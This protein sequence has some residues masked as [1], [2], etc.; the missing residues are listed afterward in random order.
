MCPSH[1]YV[2]RI[3][4]KKMENWTYHFFLQHVD[5]IDISYKRVDKLPKYRHILITCR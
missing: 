2:F 3:C 1:T 5:F 4:P